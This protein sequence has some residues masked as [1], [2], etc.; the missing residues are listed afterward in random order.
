MKFMLILTLC[1]SLYNSCMTPLKVDKLYDSHYDCAKDGYKSSGEAI[2][3]FGKQRVNDEVL[4]I[5]FTCEKIEQ[6]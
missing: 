6:T 4:Y 3:N 5:N 1:S 2:E